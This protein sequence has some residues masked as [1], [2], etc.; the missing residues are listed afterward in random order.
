MPAPV[1]FYFDF[2][3][4]TNGND[5]RNIQIVPL[6]DKCSAMISSAFQVTWSG[7][8][9]S[10]PNASIAEVIFQIAGEWNPVGLGLY[11]FR[12]QLIVSASKHWEWDISMAEGGNIEKGY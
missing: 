2:S 9:Y 7:E 1:D 10:P 12:G 4:E 6:K 5:L 8:K 3:Y 11:S